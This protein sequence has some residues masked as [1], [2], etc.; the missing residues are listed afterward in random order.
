MTVVTKNDRYNEKNDG[1]DEI[2]KKKKIHQIF[3]SACRIQ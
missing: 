1:Y 3:V 2:F